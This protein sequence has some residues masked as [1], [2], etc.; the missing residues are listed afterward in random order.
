MPLE[1]LQQMYA[2]WPFFKEM[3]DL[4]AMTLSKTDYSVSANYELQLVEQLTRTPIEE[5]A[6]IDYPHPSS[7]PSADTPSTDESACMF[8]PLGDRIRDQLV[9]T[10][11]RVLQVSGCGDLSGGF[12]LL[13]QSMRVRYPFVDPLN[14][15]QA[16]VV[17]RLRRGE[18]GGGGEV[19]E[20]G[21]RKLLEDALTVSINGIAQ[22]MKNSG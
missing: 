21:D 17:K 3:V 16:E 8:D 10:R 20:E 1:D 14:V 18:G 19:L 13:Q 11:R 22:G 7:H 2:Q 9:E 6:V 5:C 12:E 15:L 4:I